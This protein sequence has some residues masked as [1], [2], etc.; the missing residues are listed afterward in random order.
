MVAVGG[1]KSADLAAR[2]GDG[3]IGT[4]PEKEGIRRFREAGGARKPRY[5]ELTVCWARDEKSARRTA[6]EWWPTAA[7][8]GPLHWELPLPAH[9]EAAAEMVTEDAVAESVV[10]GPDPA[11]HVEAIREYA[12]AG[13]DHVCVHQ[14]GPEQKGFM[15][16]YVR[17]VFPRLRRTARRSRTAARAKGHRGRRRG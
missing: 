9:F 17:E 1:P 4:E 15:D 10:C 3:M 2:A 6:H 7:I 8:G 5:G 13:Y 12:D 14:V 11:R 16:F